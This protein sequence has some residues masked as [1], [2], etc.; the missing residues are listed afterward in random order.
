M[1]AAFIWIVLFFDKFWRGVRDNNFEGWG[2]SVYKFLC[3]VSLMEA[4]PPFSPFLAFVLCAEKEERSVDP[5]VTRQL[6]TMVMCCLQ[7]LTLGVN[8]NP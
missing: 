4:G 3:M 2:D 6:I 5:A 8:K 1:S 7:E